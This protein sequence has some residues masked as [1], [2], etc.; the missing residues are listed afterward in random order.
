MTGTSRG[1][2]ADFL[3]NIR[4]FSFGWLDV[5]EL[6]R[7]AD[8]VLEYPM[9]DRDPIAQWTFG[10]ITLV[11]DAAHPMYPRGSNG[12]AQALIDARV[13][14]DCLAKAGD[15]REALKCYEAQRAPV[16]AAIVQANR[17]RPPDVINLRVEELNGDKPFTD[18]NSLISQQEL[19]RLSNEYKEIAGFSIND[20]GSA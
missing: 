20:L 13:V 1:R 3:A 2:L 9:V 19:Q 16:T 15:P 17:T 11:G 5:P 14:A 18:L 10:R 4:G 12:S 8:S 7:N 6:I